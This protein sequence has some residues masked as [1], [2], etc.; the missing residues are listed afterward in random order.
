MLGSIEIRNLR[1]I[2][3]LHFDIP[4]RGVW[5]LTG[6]N[7][8]G[9]TSLLACL[10]RIGY[11]NAFPL[12]FPSSLQS[13]QLDNHSKGTITYSINGVSVEYAY[14][15]ERWTPRPRKNAGVFSQ[16]GYP[17]VTYIGAT[18]DRITPRPEDF[19]AHQA[20]KAPIEII[21]AA[22]SI[23]ET[24]KFSTL[25]TINLTRGTGNSA[26]V[27]ALNTSPQ[28]YHSEKHFSLGELCVLKLLRL[29]KDVNNNSMII[30]D[31][32]EMALHPR[33][34]LKLL[35]YLEEQA[36]IKSLTVIFSTHSVTLLKTINRTQI[37]YLDKT[38]TGEVTPVIGCFP[39]F[40]IGNIAYD[41]ESLP[42]IMIYVED[43]YAKRL[44]SSFY[45]FFSQEKFKEASKM[46]SIKIIPIGGFKEVISFLDRN[47]SVLPKNVIQ[48]T[49]LDKDVKD[50]SLQSFKNENQYSILGKFQ[51]C[52]RDISYLPFTP[53]VGIVE[54]IQENM[55]L[56]EASIRESFDDNQIRISGYI[57]EFNPELSGKPQRNSAKKIMKEL[58][59]YLTEKTETSEE[60]VLDRISLVFA[61]L[62][63]IKYRSD[64]MKLFGSMLTKGKK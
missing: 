13:E 49:V 15:G 8:S 51:K 31:E 43:N 63:W 56:F 35:H 27:L 33:A 4:D 42:D 47:R 17:S 59:S 32:L 60:V 22:N 24:D 58:I 62:S 37:I 36:Q 30:V 38:K 21:E 34:Q 46:P 20:R 5:L 52:E 41:E 16:F 2:S 7:G 19:D 57:S 55:K 28:T 61:T 1:N 40:A 48:K 29:I 10:Q 6:G 12:H 45:K 11:P 53:E 39:T 23:F 50:E 54:F 25:R 18:A 64:F 26:F 3:R 9:K 14:R 44:L